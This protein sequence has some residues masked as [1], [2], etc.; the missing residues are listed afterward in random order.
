M[1]QPDE[2]EMNSGYGCLAAFVLALLGLFFLSYAAECIF[3]VCR[4]SG[5]M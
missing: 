2:H 3:D 5:G 4:L 1:S